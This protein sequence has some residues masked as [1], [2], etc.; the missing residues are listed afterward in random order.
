MKITVWL[1]RDFGDSIRKEINNVV[2][3]QMLPSGNL[4]LIQYDPQKNLFIDWTIESTEIDGF[5]QWDENDVLCQ[6]YFDWKDK[7]G[8][9]K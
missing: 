7:Q 5:C 1:K 4:C 2:K 8:A 3:V 6:E 9:K